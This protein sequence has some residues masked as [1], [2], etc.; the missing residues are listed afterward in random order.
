MFINMELKDLIGVKFKYISPYSKEES[1]WV[2]IVSEIFIS[3]V[4][5]EFGK[6]IDYKF[7]P[8]IYIIS[9]HGSTYKLSEVVFLT[10]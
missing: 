5:S 8:E 10:K 4:L 9:E 6:N 2:G 1:S 3:K 7:K